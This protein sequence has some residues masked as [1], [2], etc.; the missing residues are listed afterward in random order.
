MVNQIKN[1][2][3]VSDTL[4]LEKAYQSCETLARSHYENFPVA[5][6]FL[7]K[8][9]R[10]PIAVIYAFARSADDI[11]DEGN[12]TPEER[13]VLLNN[14]WKNLENI[15]NRIP[16]NDPL[17][18]AL[19][20]TIQTHHLPIDLFFDLLKAFKQD[21]L[22][23]DYANVQEILEYCRYSANPIG[24]LLLHLT[25]QDTDNNLIA[26]DKICTALQLINFLQDLQSDNQIRKRCYLPQDQMQVLGVSNQDLQI[27]KINPE[28]NELIKNQWTLAKDLI[29]Q[30]TLL[31]AQLPGIFGYEI[32]MMI[33]CAKIMLKQLDARQNVYQRPVIS[34]KHVPFVLWHALACQYQNFMLR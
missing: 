18:L 31:G 25:H 32:R 2:M 11:A 17:F 22:K 9:L 16:I 6:R 12:H 1:T 14:Y 24:R 33:V 5:S 23:Q 10:R 3:T 21:V 34:Y 27:T 15:Q 8:K 26:S 28:I 7:A 20:H 30:G 29:Q 13:L 4:I 19:A